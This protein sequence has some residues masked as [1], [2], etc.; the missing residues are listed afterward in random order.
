MKKKLT[1]KQEQ[2]CLEYVVD[3]NAKQAAI[4]A[5]YSKKTAD[6]IGHENLNKLEVSNRVKELMQPI[7]EKPRELRQRIIDE[8][9]AIAFANAS[10]FYEEI[11]VDGK[12]HRVIRS[13]IL[14]SEKIAAISSFEPGA[15]GVKVKV[16]DKQKALE[17]LARYQGLFNADISQKPE[18]NNFDFTNISSEKLRKIQAILNDDSE[19]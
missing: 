19:S 6:R 17:M 8:L 18:T 4:R 12:K 7:R 5:G 15:Y 13:D 2:F 1:D 3:F 10:D 16:N 14:N 11:E 9:E